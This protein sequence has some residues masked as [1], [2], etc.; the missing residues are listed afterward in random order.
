[1]R[2]ITALSLNVETK[3]T[4]ISVTLCGMQAS[5]ATLTGKV[6]NTKKVGNELDDK[7]TSLENLCKSLQ[8]GL[9]EQSKKLADLKSRSRWQYPAVL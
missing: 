4:T 8:D 5:F 6:R 7:L 9:N 2:A 1:M 3:F